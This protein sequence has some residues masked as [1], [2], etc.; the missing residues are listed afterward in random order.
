[1]FCPGLEFLG[2]RCDLQVE[3]CFSL[4]LLN[5]TKRCSFNTRN[6]KK[7]SGEISAYFVI[8][9]FNTARYYNLEGLFFALEYSQVVVNIRY[10]VC[11]I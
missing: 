5:R 7:R 1:M 8:K 9:L 4:I 6:S 2:T 10:L 3:I 11:F